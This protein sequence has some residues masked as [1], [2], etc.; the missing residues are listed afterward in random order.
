MVF[1]GG[2]TSRSRGVPR[3]QGLDQGLYNLCALGPRL[4]Y[5][6]RYED[7]DRCTLDQGA[8][9]ALSERI[10]GNDV[11]VPSVHLEPESARKLPDFCEQGLDR[12]VRGRQRGGGKYVFQI[13]GPQ[14][15]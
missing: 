3:R 7:A 2:E 12:A 11:A 14:H 10:V 13:L 15:D 4:A 8:L 9:D 5:D 1:M 6:A